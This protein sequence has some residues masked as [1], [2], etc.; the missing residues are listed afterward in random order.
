MRSDLPKVLHDVCGRPMLHFVLRA[1]REAG[2]KRLVVVAG[3]GKDR[4][5]EAFAGDPSIAW[6]EQ[7]EQKG[8]GHAV[9]CC[10][11][12]LK[13]V[14]GSVL[15]IAADMPLVRGEALA[16][17]LKEREQRGDAV[18]IATTELDDPAG[19]GR[20][21]RDGSGRPEAIVEDR[22]CTP[23]QR[24]I[25]EVNVSYYCFDRTQLFDA[26]SELRP[27]PL[28][29]EYYLTDTIGILRS[30]GHGVS[31]SLSVAP[32]DALGINSRADLAE[33]NRIMQRRIQAA[34][35][36]EGVTITSPENTWIEAD[37]EVGAESTIAPFSFVG[38]GAR[39][40]C[41]CR[42][43]PFAHVPPGAVVADGG[44]IGGA[45]EMGNSGP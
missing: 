40:G 42:I 14:L 32:Q 12:A 23:Q 25:R 30:K 35:M 36:S 34:V 2:V 3:H 31:A 7:K 5:V 11:E 43:G 38:A 9:L 37:A 33:V 39:I 15:V 29:G 18:T 8:T 6:V 26:L 17:L 27:N 13:D 20:I 4:V 41:G 10:R 21:V 28:K 44:F 1:C 24:R 16:S 22:D 19:Y 45:S